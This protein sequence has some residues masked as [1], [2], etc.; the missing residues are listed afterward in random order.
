[1]YLY[2]IFG[3]NYAPPVDQ[4]NLIQLESQLANYDLDFL[5]PPETIIHFETFLELGCLLT[6]F[7][8]QDC[9]EKVICF[10]TERYGIILEM[11]K[12][13]LFSICLME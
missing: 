12:I 5:F 7:S 10:C 13:S 8:Y 3:V 2:P 4:S 6:C 1:M 11:E 9:N